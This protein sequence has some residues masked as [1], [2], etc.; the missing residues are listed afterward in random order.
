ML[1]HKSRQITS[2]YVSYK[3]TPQ[4]HQLRLDIGYKQIKWLPL[5]TE[6]FNRTWR[7]GVPVTLARER[8]NRSGAPG[9]GPGISLP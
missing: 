1:Q 8:H 2:A 7:K 3:L 4:F 9:F 6:C 5:L